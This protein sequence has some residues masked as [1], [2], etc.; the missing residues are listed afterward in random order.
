MNGRGNRSTRRKPAPA[1]L[2]PPQIPL[3]QTRDW[4]RAAAVGRGRMFLPDVH[5]LIPDYSGH[6]PEDGTL[7]F[8]SC[9]GTK[10]QSLN[11]RLQWTSVSLVSFL[12]QWVSMWKRRLII[13]TI[14]HNLSPRINQICPF[15]GHNITHYQLVSTRQSETASWSWGPCKQRKSPVLN[16]VVFIITAL[17]YP[18]GRR[19][20][21]NWWYIFRTSAIQLLM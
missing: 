8:N 16:S 5:E 6:I 21:S 13:V 10:R 4:T 18:S 14:Q 1:P 12:W 2:C 9:F 17:C 11:D 3:D 15:M 20:W 7:Y 19:R